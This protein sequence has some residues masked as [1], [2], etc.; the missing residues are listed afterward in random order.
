MIL[1]LINRKIKPIFNIPEPHI[2]KTDCPTYV[3]HESR[4]DVGNNDDTDI[5]EI[6]PKLTCSTTG[7]RN[8]KAIKKFAV[9][10]A[11]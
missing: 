3:Y 1:S 9:M 8:Y 2:R 5:F 4:P 11:R 10:C 7:S 6:P